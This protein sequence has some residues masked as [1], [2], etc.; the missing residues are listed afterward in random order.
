MRNSLF[1]TAC[2]LVAFRL[3]LAA[4]EA[5]KD[6][7]SRGIDFIETKVYSEA[8]DA[9]LLKLYDGLRVVDVSDGLHMA[10]LPGQCL[11]DASIQPAWKNYETLGHQFR[12][13]AITMR[14]VPTQ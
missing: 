12:G 9:R 14:Y 10:G 2:L 7:L 4:Q 6:E 13:I 8:E 5:A 1:W 11:V 3:P